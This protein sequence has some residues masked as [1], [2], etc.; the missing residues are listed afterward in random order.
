MPG[1]TGRRGDRPAWALCE[2]HGTSVNTGM[3]MFRRG[4]WKYV[5]YVGYEPQL[6]DLANDPGEIRD[7]AQDKRDVVR[8][9]D[10]HL[11]EIVDYEEVDARAKAY[12]RHSFRQWRR[13]QL[14]AGTYQRTIS[15]IY[16]GWD[17]LAD[18]EIQPW[19]DADERQIERWLR[20]E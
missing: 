7:L 12:D 11:R 1:L 17:D 5:T 6:F 4:N 18:D 19:T 9:M 16:S 15:R 2:F 20:G 10:A 13:E 3:T 14:A 8:E